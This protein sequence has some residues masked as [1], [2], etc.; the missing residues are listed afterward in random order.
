VDL[1]FGL[2]AVTLLATPGPEPSQLA[3]YPQDNANIPLFA[4]NPTA[5]ANPQRIRAVRVRLS[6]RSAV[7]DRAADIVADNTI[8]Q[9]AFFRMQLGPQ[10]FARVRTL[11]ADVALPNHAGIQW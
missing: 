8:P 5:G 2:T 1:K 6:V 4:G 3:G 10:A 11:Q 9:G 7:P